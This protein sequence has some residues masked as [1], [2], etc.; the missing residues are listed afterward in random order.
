MTQD[1]HCDGDRFLWCI[2]LKGRF[3]CRCFWRH[4]D[5]VEKGYGSGRTSG[6]SQ[7]FELILVGA[8][9]H[10]L[11]YWD[12]SGVIFPQIMTKYRIKIIAR[13]KCFGYIFK[14]E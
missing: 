5:H 2:T 6:C 8:D 3:N 12:W 1:I 13:L 9:A 10:S 4:T 11:E 14:V 7:C